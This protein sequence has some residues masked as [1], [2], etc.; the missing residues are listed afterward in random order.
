MLAKALSR[1]SDETPRGPCERANKATWN[2]HSVSFPSISVD[3][4][5]GSSANKVSFPRKSFT[6]AV[7]GSERPG[8]AW[9]AS[10]YNPAFWNV[11][12]LRLCVLPPVCFWTIFLPPGGASRPHS[13]S[14]SSCPSATHSSSCFR[15]ARPERPS[16]W[17]I[18]QG[19][20]SPTV[21]ALLGAQLAEVGVRLCTHTATPARPRPLPRDCGT[22]PPFEL[23]GR[24]E[25]GG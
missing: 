15:R 10:G 19:Y 3:P 13:W 11:H 23:G 12:C 20:V 18:P 14:S 25:I 1:F 8:L 4:L 6:E 7:E 22:R 5:G 21:C 17:C 2:I 9:E 16:A 24:V